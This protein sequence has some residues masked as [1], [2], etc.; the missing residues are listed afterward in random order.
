MNQ[1][2]F[3]NQLITRG[4]PPCIVD[5]ETTLKKP[6]ENRKN[7]KTLPG[8]L[9]KEGHTAAIAGSETTALKQEVG[10]RQ[11]ETMQIRVKTYKTMWKLY[12]TT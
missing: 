6:L 5:M 11:L 8:A 9:K 12:E 7:R 4:A 10:K 1:I 3:I 2:W